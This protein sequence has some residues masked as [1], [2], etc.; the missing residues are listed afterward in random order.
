MSKPVRGLSIDLWC[1][2]TGNIPDSLGHTE[3]RGAAI[4]RGRIIDDPR[5]IQPW[6]AVKRDGDEEASKVLNAR[7]LDCKENRVSN[8]GKNVQNGENTASETVFISN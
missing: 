7:V 1:H 4:V 5:L 2:Y 8:D 3:K 6:A